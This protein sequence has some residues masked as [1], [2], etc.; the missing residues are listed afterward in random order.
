MKKILLACLCALVLVVDTRAA[1]SYDTSSSGQ[2]SSSTLATAVT[3]GAGANRALLAWIYHAGTGVAPSTVTTSFGQSLTKVYDKAF[4]PAG[5]QFCSARAVWATATTNINARLS[6]WQL[7]APTSGATTVTAT[8]GGATPSEL[9]LVAF[10]GVDQTTPIEPLVETCTTVQSPFTV[11][12]DQAGPLA[13]TSYSNYPGAGA[14]VFGFAVGLTGATGLAKVGLA[15]DD[16]TLWNKLHN[17]TVNVG[18]L[19]LTPSPFR[20]GTM[21]GIAAYDGFERVDWITMP[22]YV[23]PAGVIYGS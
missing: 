10:A 23:R 9:G 4:G 8:F 7:V 1:V 15:L 2:T 21:P 12:A 3:I 22:I 20:S 5:N 14:I 13:F 17:N 11:D 6:I 16:Q 18:V 19:R